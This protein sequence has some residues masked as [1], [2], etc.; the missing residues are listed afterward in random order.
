MVMM[1]IGCTGS[2]TDETDYQSQSSPSTSQA[3]TV[4]PTITPVE[5]EKYEDQQW[6]N[7]LGMDATASGD[8]L[9]D[10]NNVQN[11]CTNVET[12]GMNLIGEYAQNLYQ[13]SDA[14]YKHSNSY[15]VSPDLQPAKDE[16]NQGL[17]EVNTVAVKLTRA[18][19]SYNKG[20]LDQFETEVTSVQTLINSASEH[21][22]TG[23]TLINKYNA[24]KSI[25]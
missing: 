11:A 25:D 19:D 17:T 23:E 8:L 12:T 13:S 6:L 16:Y 14:A 9:T 24:E 5:T 20:D 18:V 3:A 21:F 22:K 4:D 1:G 10:L 15:N 7:A 2:E